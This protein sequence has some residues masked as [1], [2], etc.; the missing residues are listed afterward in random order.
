M[1]PETLRPDE[2]S[3]RRRR[4]ADLL[5]T[6]KPA[7]GE[8][9]V[10]S[11]FNLDLLPPF[12]AEALDRYG[13]GAR[14]WLAGF[15]QL[16]AEIAN[17]AS[18]LYARAPRDVLLVP[19]PEDL[20]A[21]LYAGDDG[22]DPLGLTAER[23]DELRGQVQ[24]L[25][26]RLP[27]ATIHVAVM[28]AQRAPAEHLLAPAAPGRGQAALARLDA[29]VRDLGELG[30][31]VVI[32][33]FDWAARQVGRAAVHD[34]R[35]WYLGRMRL[36]PAG[37]ALLAEVVA[38]GM[39]VHRGVGRRKVAAVDLDD[40]LWGGVVGE[41]GPTGIE[42]GEEGVALAFQDFQRELVR[43]H[44][45]GVLI[46]LCTK[47]DPEYALAAFD[48]PS[49]VLRRE[50][51][52]ADRVNWRDKA[53]NLR[54]LAAE[55]ELGLDSFVFFDDNPR[56]REWIRQALPMVTVPELPADPT[57]RPAF[58]ARGQW[59]GTL[60]VT[61]ADR[62]RAATYRAQGRR[63][64]AQ[65]SAASFEDYLESLE[66]RLTIEPVTDATVPR[67]AQLCQRTNQFNLTT[68]RHTEADVERMLADP[69]YDLVTVSVTDRFGDSGITGL[70]ITLHEDGR[71]ELDTLLL[72]CRLLGR[73]VEDAFLAVLARR[74]RER[75]ASTLLGAYE[76]TA[77][78]AQVAAFFPDRGFTPAGERRWE[79]D[80]E[81]DLPEPPPHLTI[82]EPA[83]A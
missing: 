61:D 30:G 18:E 55:L 36:N 24:T 69:A 48:H 81:A 15:G 79:L 66:Q 9:A 47:N 52:V 35:L 7:A 78:N 21:P 57:E 71:A 64:R 53:T 40:T 28:G 51:V 17:P 10:L 34:A 29:G 50:H 23:V 73:S 67:A 43:L 46:V 58:L 72:S 39:A 8:L 75:G 14:L 74:A 3:A 32:V 76:P 1:A 68:R 2:L 41:V 45:S 27:G 11:T 5:R 42:V 44:D 37:H 33:D 4:G 54:E 65:A 63:R 20:L 82:E 12:L 60:A 16:A 26:E 62:T 70:A 31:R 80:L 83:H 19:A 77:R 13:V 38:R 6:A 56:E 49:M 22:A 59:F 25:L